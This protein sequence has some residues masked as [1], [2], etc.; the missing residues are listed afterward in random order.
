MSNDPSRNR[1]DRRGR[2]G[3]GT[4]NSRPKHDVFCERPGWQTLGTLVSLA[5]VYLGVAA[6]TLLDQPGS[7]GIAGG[8][9]SLAAG[10]A[11]AGLLISAA[12][13]PSATV[14]IATEALSA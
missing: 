7:W 2:G 4:K 14:A 3:Y 6:I 8:L 13:Q 1:H 12:R 9:V 11:Y 10:L 5:Y